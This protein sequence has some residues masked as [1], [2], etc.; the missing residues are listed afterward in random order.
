MVASRQASVPRSRLAVVGGWCGRLRHRP[1]PFAAVGIRSR[2]MADRARV[3]A[4][5]DSM[6]NSAV[7][8]P[9]PEL[10]RNGGTRPSTLAAHGTSALPMRIRQEPSAW[11]EIGVTA[12]V[13][14]ALCGTW[15]G[16]LAGYFVAARAVHRRF[17]RI[18]TRPVRHHGTPRFCRTSPARS[19]LCSACGSPPRSDWRQRCHSSALA[20]SRR[21]KLGHM[22]RDGMGDLVGDP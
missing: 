1:E 11:R 21:T 12:P 7:T 13:L 3:C 17:D 16:M 15:A 2:A 19:S 4:A 14:A 8:Q 9:M 6:P 20:R 18:G 10:R 22:I 5:L